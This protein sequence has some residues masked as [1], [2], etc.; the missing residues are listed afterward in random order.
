M[1][2]R[3]QPLPYKDGE[4]SL[5]GFLAVDDALND[6][7][8]PGVMVV[9]GGAGPDEHARRRAVR[10]AELGF[11]AFA[12][13]MYGDGV[14]GHRER[15]MAC[16]KELMDD[17]ERLRQRARAGLFILSAHPEV[18]G[19][20]AA[21]GY[22]F[23]GMTVLELARSGLGLAGVVSVH[24]SMQTPNPAEPG[25]IKTQVLVCHG[26][27]DPHVP[28]PQVSAFVEEMNRA[29]AD[30]QLIAYGGAMHGFTHEDATSETTPGVAYDARTDAR[31]WIAMR[32]FF[33]EIF[34]GSTKD[35]MDMRHRLW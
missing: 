33:R 13:D 11:V 35:T 10:L 30:W 27:L 17:R 20:L 2:M 22:C 7:R 5:T 28:M 6:R 1:A 15:V 26:A 32:S 34:G 21:V 4:T 14:A 29:G 31:C 8:R 16:I 25:S 19:R 18:D 23:G 24:G 12:C 3:T 9:H